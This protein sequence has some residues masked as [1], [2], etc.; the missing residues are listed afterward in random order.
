[1]LN[2]KNLPLVKQRGFIQG[3]DAERQKFVHILYLY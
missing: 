3:D 1:M 2:P